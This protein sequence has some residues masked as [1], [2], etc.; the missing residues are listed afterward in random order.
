MNIYCI[1]KM[2]A[3]QIVNHACNNIDMQ[4]GNPNETLN[5]TAGDVSSTDHIGIRK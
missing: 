4:I 3:N 1:A 5:D 2:I